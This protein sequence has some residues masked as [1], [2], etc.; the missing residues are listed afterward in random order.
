M[1]SQN[2]LQDGALPMASHITGYRCPAN[3]ITNSQQADGALSILYRTQGAEGSQPTMKI[4]RS[5]DIN[6]AYKIKDVIV[7]MNVMYNKCE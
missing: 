7:R 3:N 5:E 4:R 6:K 2:S 1:E